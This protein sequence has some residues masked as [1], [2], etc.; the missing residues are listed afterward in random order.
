MVVVCVAGCSHRTGTVLVHCTIRRGPAGVRVFA[1]R[2]HLRRSESHGQTLHG[3]HHP[4]DLTQTA[5]KR[6]AHGLRIV[7]HTAEGRTCLVGGTG[8]AICDDESHHTTSQV[9]R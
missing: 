5:A 4:G 2:A 3:D 1:L 9:A 8:V 7:S 6:G